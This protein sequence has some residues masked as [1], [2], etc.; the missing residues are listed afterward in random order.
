MKDFILAIFSIVLLLVIIFG[1]T[2]FDYFN[3]TFWGPKYQN[4]K[5][6]IFENSNAYVRGTQR[7]FQNLVLEYHKAQTAEEKQA[8]IS[9]LRQRAYGTPP[10]QVPPEVSNLLNQPIQ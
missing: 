4:A 9:V 1:F 7:D 8:I 5:T 2:A 3:L 10:E 6:Q